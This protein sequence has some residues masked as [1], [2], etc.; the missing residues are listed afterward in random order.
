MGVWNYL[1]L[2]ARRY[3][4]GEEREFVGM[5]VGMDGD[6]YNGEGSRGGQSSKKWQRGR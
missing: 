2:T 1:V 6:K 5:L 3:S 4:A